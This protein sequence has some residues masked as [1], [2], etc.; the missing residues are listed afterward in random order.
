MLKQVLY[1]LI[2]GLRGNIIYF[3]DGKVLE[4]TEF[5]A[6]DVQRRANK[7]FPESI[8]HL[9]KDGQLILYLK[10]TKND[11]V[12]IQDSRPVKYGDFLSYNY[13]GGYVLIDIFRPYPQAP[14]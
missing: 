4:I 14:Y 7:N 5:V 13:D 8:I 6:L 12:I 10:I 2:K 3:K 11:K 1:A 9:N